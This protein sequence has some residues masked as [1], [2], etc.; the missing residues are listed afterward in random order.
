VLANDKNLT[1]K[2][3]TPKAITLEFPKSSLAKAT[4]NITLQVTKTGDQQQ[5]KILAKC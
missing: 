1:L 2:L 3:F 5:F 4:S